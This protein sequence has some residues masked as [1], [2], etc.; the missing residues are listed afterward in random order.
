MN[1][2]KF[3]FNISD[4]I[5]GVFIANAHQVLTI[6]SSLLKR[7]SSPTKGPVYFLKKTRAVCS[8]ATNQR[9]QRIM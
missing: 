7:S 2:E 3:S 5:F 4:C 8:S 9:F 1:Y 6:S